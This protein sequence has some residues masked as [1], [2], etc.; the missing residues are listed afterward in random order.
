MTEMSHLTPI[1]PQVLK[2]SWLSLSSA[3]YDAS[4]DTI[5]LRFSYTFFSKTITLKHVAD[6][7]DEDDD[8]DERGDDARRRRLRHA[9][10]QLAL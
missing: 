9:S 2:D 3:T 4:G 1:A 8:D 10:R 6:A 7:A 5:A